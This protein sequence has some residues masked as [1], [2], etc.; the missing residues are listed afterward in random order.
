[1]R[2]IL[3]EAKKIGDRREA[4]L[5]ASGPEDVLRQTLADLWEISRAEE[6]WLQGRQV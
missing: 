5:G 3:G 6:E 2:E 1:M 4:A